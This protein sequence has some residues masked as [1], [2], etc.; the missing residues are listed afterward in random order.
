MRKVER[1]KMNTSVGSLGTDGDPNKSPVEVI[2]GGFKSSND[3]PPQGDGTD[4]PNTA[5][6]EESDTEGSDSKSED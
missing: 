4:L 5:G 6:T 3:Q 2:L 1:F